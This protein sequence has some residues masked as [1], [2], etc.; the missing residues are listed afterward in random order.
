MYKPKSTNVDKLKLHKTK[1]VK[2]KR[3][4]RVE[5]INNSLPSNSYI[6]SLGDLLEIGLDKTEAL[7]VLDRLNISNKNKLHVY[8]SQLR[9]INGTPLAVRKE[10]VSIINKGLKK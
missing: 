9:H 2:Y 1:A 3:I 4:E 7:E 8:S 6:V 5:E 10:K